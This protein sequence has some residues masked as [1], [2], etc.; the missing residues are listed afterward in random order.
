[1][2]YNFSNIVIG[3]D[4]GTGVF[5]FNNATLGSVTSVFIDVL[6]QNSVDM[7]G[8]INT[9]DDS[10]SAIKGYL[11][12]ISDTNG[13]NSHAIFSVSALASAATYY[14]LTVSFVS[15]AVFSNLEAAVVIFHHNGN[16]G[17]QGPIGPIGP[18]GP[19]GPIGVSGPT[20]ARGPQGPIGPIGVSG[21]QGPI[22]PIGVSGP[23]GPAGPSTAINAS[24]TG[25]G[26]AFQVLGVRTPGSNDTPLV[27]NAPYS[28]TV[29]PNQG[30]VHANNFISYS[31]I[32]S[33]NTYTGG[34]PGW[35]G[36]GSITLY[37][38][39]G[40]LGITPATA[41]NSYFATISTSGTQLRFATQAGS[42]YASIT[43]SGITSIGDVTAYGTPSDIKLKENI[44]RIPN[45]LEMI[46]SLNGYTFNYIGKTD[47]MIG[48]IAQELEKIAP[49]L[50][51][52]TESL[53]T[54][55]TSKAVRYS[56][57]TA[58]L[59]EAVKELS[60]EIKELKK[61]LP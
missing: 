34:T 32:S 46:E 17:P 9:W 55:E 7:S 40:Q 12:I 33:G 37:G 39:Y 28:V 20:G 2:R 45:G 22:G 27:S 19:Q 11:E 57:I 25:S 5:A 26:T 54:G 10:T 42:V 16:I 43:S 23:Q 48:V 49:E 8:Y 52:E 13:D 51:Y 6:D 1:M 3:G 31:Y 61:R 60:A 56:Q 18:S 59:I 30:S 50:V 21:P 38:D 15:G 47:R 35:P 36:G 14:T 53:E 44:E 41:A 4:P 58:I 29:N 24:T